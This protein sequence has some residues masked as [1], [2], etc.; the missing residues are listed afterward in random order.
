VSALTGDAHGGGDVGDRTS[1]LDAPAQQESTSG[2]KGSVT[3][4]HKDL[5]KG[6]LD[7][8]SA[9]LL[10]EVFHLVDPAGVNNVRG[11]YT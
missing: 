6:V 10:P 3:V 8:S 11:K 4:R 9:H 5:R 2:G 1:G 7:S